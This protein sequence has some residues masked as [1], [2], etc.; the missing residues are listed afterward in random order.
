M[1]RLIHDP[2]PDRMD[3][4]FLAQ[5][6]TGPLFIAEQTG[7]SVTH[8]H[9]RSVVVLI[10]AIE[11]MPPLQKLLHDILQSCKLN[12]PQDTIIQAVESGTTWSW[13][14][15]Q[16]TWNPAVLLLFGIMLN[17]LGQSTLSPYQPATI[18]QA[19]VLYADGLAA[20]H[21]DKSRKKLLWQALKRIFF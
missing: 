14:Q 6:F 15:I 4:Y 2:M 5:L 10:Q 9:S 16:Q 21:E 11:Q 8:T 18:D 20:L 7:S 19:H 17:D 12:P 1:E 13:K 3:A